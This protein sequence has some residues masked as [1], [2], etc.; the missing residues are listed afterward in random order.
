L[1]RGSIRVEPG[2]R[3]R[4]GDTIGKV[5]NS[6]NSSEPHVH[7]HLQDTSTHSFGEAIPM[8]FQGYRL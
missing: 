7:L 5:G 4:A 1:Q 6:G 2:Q 3:V 8:F